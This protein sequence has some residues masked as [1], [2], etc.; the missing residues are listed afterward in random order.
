MEMMQLDTWTTSVGDPDYPQRLAGH[1]R[2]AEWPTLFGMGRRGILG[3]ACLGLICSIKCPGAAVIKAFDA[4]R[5]LRDTGVVVAGGFHS[6]MERECLEFLLRGEQ[7]AIVCPA[8]GLGHP[9][10][11]AAQREALKGGRLML[12]SI[13]RDTINRTTKGQAHERNEFVAALA[14][15]VLIPHASPGGNA[16]TIA[17]QVLEHGKPV[18]TF[19][20]EENQGLLDRG[21]RLYDTEAIRSVITSQQEAPS[22]AAQST[23][24]KG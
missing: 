21:A 18:F 16:E 10:L 2:S 9:G 22:P 3:E 14:C 7:P 8:K 17:R 1:S 4:V 6:P 5:E 13:F 15:A 24:R 23:D 11:S 20:V 19:D 12:L